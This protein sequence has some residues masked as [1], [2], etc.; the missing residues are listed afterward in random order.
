MPPAITAPPLKMARINAPRD[1]NKKDAPQPGA[2]SNPK[3]GIMPHISAT[4]QRPGALCTAMGLF[5]CLGLALWSGSAMAAKKGPLE[6]P[7]AYAIKLKK[8]PKGGKSAYLAGEATPAGSNLK[9]RGLWATQPVRI[10]VMPANKSQAVRMEL[11]KYH[12]KPALRSCSTKGRDSC[13]L[14]FSNQGDVFIKLIAP[15]GPAKVYLAVKV[16]EMP[17]PQKPA[18]TP[19]GAKP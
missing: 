2:V 14:A 6:E 15:G 10:V 11:R 18:L 12:W 1:Y 3:G 19:K 5:L 9:L 16:G 13:G 17:K 8:G 7:E 4:P